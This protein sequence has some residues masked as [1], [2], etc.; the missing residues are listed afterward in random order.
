MFSRDTL[1]GILFTSTIP[2]LLYITAIHFHIYINHG[3][4]A[5]YSLQFIIKSILALLLLLFPFAWIIIRYDVA[6]LPK[7]YDGSSAVIVILFFTYTAL[8]IISPLLANDMKDVTALPF[9]YLF[10]KL[11][12]HIKNVMWD[13]WNS[14]VYKCEPEQLE[15][16]SSESI[17]KNRQ[18]FYQE[19]D[20]ISQF[21]KTLTCPAYESDYIMEQLTSKVKNTLDNWKDQSSIGLRVLDIGGA[22]GKFTAKLL[23]SLSE[24]GIKIAFIKMIDPVDWNKEYTDHLSK[25][26][27]NFEIEFKNEPFNPDNLKKESNYDLIIASHSLYSYIDNIRANGIHNRTEHIK[28]A[29]RPLYSKPLINENGI[30]II[31]LSSEYGSSADFKQNGISMLFGEN[32]SDI[33]AEQIERLIDRKLLSSGTVDNLFVFSG[34]HSKITHR[35]HIPHLLDNWLSYYLRVNID[36]LQ[37]QQK[38]YLREELINKLVK[39]NWLS[40]SEINKAMTIFDMSNITRDVYVLPHKT[41]IIIL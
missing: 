37:P 28:Q 20:I 9:N 4:N 8:E 25:L 21:Q 3:I 10:P 15:E 33:T 18:R 32:I 12:T 17:R 13:A 34:L 24:H 39:L 5:I 27:M 14:D 29:I 41:R 30:T 38:D 22:E 26:K 40:E 16:I 23:H 36:D 6:K 11:F 1:F 7:E 31:T 2:A 35:S 19:K